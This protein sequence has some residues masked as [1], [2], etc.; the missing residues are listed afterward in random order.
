MTD[1]DDDAV[2]DVVVKSSNSPVAREWQ[3]VNF[4]LMILRFQLRLF[5]LGKLFDLSS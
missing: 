5:F 2:V 1:K 4:I 3:A